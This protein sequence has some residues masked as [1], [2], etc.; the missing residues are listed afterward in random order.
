MKYKHF[1]GLNDCYTNS[2]IDACQ[3]Y[4][5][6]Y[7]PLLFYDALH[8]SFLEKKDKINN[9]LFET[10]SK[11]KLEERLNEMFGISSYEASKDFFLN[12][13]EEVAAV[14]FID[15]Y[16]APWIKRKYMKEHIAHG[17]LALIKNKRVFLYDSTFLCDTL[18]LDYDL[19]QSQLFLGAEIIVIDKKKIYY[20]EVYFLYKTL[21]HLKA[22][23]YCS[24]L[25]KFVNDFNFE[26]YKINLKK[27]KDCF[28]NDL[29]SFVYALNGSR[30]SFNEYIEMQIKYIDNN[31]IKTSLNII[32]TKITEELKILEKIK[33]LFIYSYLQEYTI[34][35]H[36]KIVNLLYNIL[37]IEYYVKEKFIVMME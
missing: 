22:N 32:Q 33:T 16:Y 10:I 29:S 15:S 28:D 23:D 14:L 11:K 5:P 18:L 21:N 1:N 6:K 24:Q 4:Y 34:S 12:A 30:S 13:Q 20:N 17:A 3:H 7:Y 35:T 26:F 25:T 31:S 9:I 36:E 8:F 37:K 27:G 19:F 2:L